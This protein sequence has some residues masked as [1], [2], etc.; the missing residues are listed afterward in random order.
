[1][2]I[3]TIRQNKNDA[4]DVVVACALKNTNIIL[5]R[6]KNNDTTKQKYGKQT[7]NNQHILYT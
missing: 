3:Q 2:N 1:M 4:K 7:T 5:T 6:R